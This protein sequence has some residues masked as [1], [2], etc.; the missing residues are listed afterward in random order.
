MKLIFKK[1]RKS[2]EKLLVD[3]LKHQTGLIFFTCRWFSQKCQFSNW[4]KRFL[5]V[6]FSVFEVKLL[7]AGLVV[8][9]MEM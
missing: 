5:K 9:E 4:E 3:D 7:W 1:F 8:S 6:I 2:I